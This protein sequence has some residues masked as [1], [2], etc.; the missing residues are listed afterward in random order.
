MHESVVCIK[1]SQNANLLISPTGRLRG[2]L[3]PRTRDSTQF[4]LLVM[5]SN[6]SETSETASSPTAGWVSFTLAAAAENS[7]SLARIWK[8]RSRG[9]MAWNVIWIQSQSDSWKWRETEE[10]RKKSATVRI[11]IGSWKKAARRLVEFDTFCL[12]KFNIIPRHTEPSRE[13]KR[14]VNKT[15]TS[16]QRTSFYTFLSRHSRARFFLPHDFM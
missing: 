12:C 13:A 5:I 8:F 7:N 9:L 15:F 1:P 11:S 14:R 2:R 3:R 10:R 6:C 16:P 4:F